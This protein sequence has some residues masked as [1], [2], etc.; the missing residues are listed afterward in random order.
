MNLD[1]AIE[2]AGLSTHR[3]TIL[4]LARPCVTVETRRASGHKFSV[5]ASVFGGVPW[6]RAGETWPR[7]GKEP[8]SHLATINL[9]Q[10]S[11]HDVTGLLPRSGLLQFWYVQD[12]STWGFDPK[13]AGSFRVDYL[14]DTNGLAQAEVPSDV[15]PFAASHALMHAGA[16]LPNSEWIDE[17]AREHVTLGGSEAYDSLMESVYF[18]HRLLGHASPVQ[19]PMEGEC[20]GIFGGPITGSERKS[21]AREWI[22]LM[23]FETDEEGPGWMWGDAGALY[24]WIRKQD[25][26]AMR[27]DRVWCVLQCA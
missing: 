11:E 3:A 23:Q 7:Y 20:A 18:G 5:D 12:Q 21:G 24:F 13:D 8:L 19:G 22:L 1:L 27:F 14:R 2:S 15:E 10:A 26:A 6:M 16:T 25:L 17:F 4:A 9:A